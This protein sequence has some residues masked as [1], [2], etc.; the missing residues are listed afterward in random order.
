VL[1]FDLAREVLRGGLDVATSAGCHVGGGHSVDDPEPKYGM[2][3][4]GLVD[5]DRLIRNDAA[6]AGTALSLTKPLGVGVLNSRMKATGEVSV[7]AIA[8]MTA[9][10]REASQAAVAAGIRAGTDVTGFG[11]L[12]H[13]YKMARASG[14]TAVVDASAVPYLT[15]ARQALADGFVSGGTRRNLDWVRPHTD[16]SAVSDDEA[17]LLAD[18]QTSGGLLL[19]GEIPGAPVIGEFVPRGEFVVAVR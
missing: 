17:L 6:V 19:G 3:V 7:E 9:L 15:G 1:P 10:N 18:A 16:L 4:T 2:A 8:S 11:L 13:L 5:V 12:G 14:V